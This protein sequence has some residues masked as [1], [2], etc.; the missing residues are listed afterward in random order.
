M[1]QSQERLTQLADRLDELGLMPLSQ[2]SGF[3]AGVIVSPEAIPPEDWVPEVFTPESDDQPMPF[4]NFEEFASMLEL[5]ME[6]HADVL[7]NLNEGHYEPIYHDDNGDLDWKPWAR[8]FMR[9]TYVCAEAWED[10]L[11]NYDGDATQAASSLIVLA[12]IAI[13]EGVTLQDDDEGSHARERL[14]LAESG[15]DVIP[16]CV[17]SLYDRL[18]EDHARPGKTVVKGVKVGRNDPCPCGS[19]KKFKKCCG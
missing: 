15:L 5:V 6:H 8:G 17:L 12:D 1:P 13:G 2:L 10:L 4:E 7:E 14:A 16:G 9:A 19:G 18:D 3:L 11:A